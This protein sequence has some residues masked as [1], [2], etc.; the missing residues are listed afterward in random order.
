MADKN[1]NITKKSLLGFLAL[2]FLVVIISVIMA[3]GGEQSTSNNDTSQANKVACLDVSPAVT[4]LIASNLTIDGVGTIRNLKAVQ[5]NDFEKVYFVSG[6]L[7]GPGLEGERDIATFATNNIENAT[8]GVLVLSVNNVADEFSD[9]FHGP[10]TDHNT[11]MR[12]H[13]ARESQ[14]CVE[15]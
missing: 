1:T 8:G 9:W 13:G 3:S 15:K 10:D 12:N 14:E 6:D 2:I 5:S 11:T 7:Q 4:E